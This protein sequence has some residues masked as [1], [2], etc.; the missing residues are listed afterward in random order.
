MIFSK[1]IFFL[2]LSGLLHGSV[3]VTSIHLFGGQDEIASNMGDTTRFLNVK[4]SSPVTVN[5][6]KPQS[7]GTFK[8]S[9]PVSVP[10]QSEAAFSMKQEKG[11]LHLPI[12]Y[13]EISRQRGEEGVVD[14][15]VAVNRIG[16]VEEVIVLKSSGYMRLDGE[17]VR[18]AKNLEGANPGVR[19]FSVR[20]KL[21]DL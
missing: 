7:Q 15:R 3:I 4:I 1:Y 13:P 19:D 9:S 20:F 10:A 6:I 8:K 16:V 18:A 21:D 11:D 14:L 12:L 5:K 2:I 17:A